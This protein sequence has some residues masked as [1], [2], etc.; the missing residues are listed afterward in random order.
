M[1]RV[2]VFLFIL[3][4]WPMSAL[5]HHS[6]SYHFDDSRTISFEG[7][8]KEFRLINPH[9]H[10]LLD[11]TDE[12]GVT[13]E[14]DCELPSANAMRRDGWTDEVFL[15]GQAIRITGSAARHSETSCAYDLGVFADGSQIEREQSFL[16]DTAAGE[17]FSS[18]LNQVEGDIPQF[19]RIWNGV[20][21]AGGGGG[22]PGP[23][24]ANPYEYLMSEAGLAAFEAYDAVVDDPSLQCSPV[25]ISRVWRTGSPTQIQQSAEMVTIK[26]EWMDAE[27]TVYLNQ[28]EHP[29]NFSAVLGHSI[30]WYEGSTLVIDTKGYSPGVLH[31]HPG[32]PHS[33]Q[34]HT[35]ERVELDEANNLLHV[36]MVAVD[37]LYFLEPLEQTLRSYQPSTIAPR[38]YNCTH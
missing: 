16:A 9:S 8:I 12:A 10:L 21:N 11:V 20:P 25:S 24:Q 4:S 22:P 3:S 19:S 17:N 27:R 5:A 15:P 30:G 2:L 18:A 1:K 33:D 13:R 14:W 6:F 38:P 28:R 7:V 32:L 31:Q 35:V 36:S 37:P 29:E 34:L 23:D 26:H